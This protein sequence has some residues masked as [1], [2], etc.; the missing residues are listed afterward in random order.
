MDMSKIFWMQISM[1][2]NNKR[3]QGNKDT[4]PD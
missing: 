4:F 3:D 2:E 1:K